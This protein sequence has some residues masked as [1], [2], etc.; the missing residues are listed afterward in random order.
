VKKYFATA[1]LAFAACKGHKDVVKDPQTT[2]PTDAPKPAWVSARP[3]ADYDYIGIGTCPKTRADYQ[4]SAKK[5]ALNDMASEISVRVEGNSLLSSLDDKTHFT[6]TFNSNIRTST[7]EQLEGYEQVD[8][9]QNATE[10]WVYY[11]LSKAEHARIK[12]AKKNQAIALAKDGYMRAQQQLVNGDLK[13]AFDQDLRA[14]IAMKEYWGESDVVTIGDREVPLAN[15]IF[16]DLQRLTNGVRFSALPE[17]CALDYTNRFKRELLVSAAFADGRQSRDLV[18]LPVVIDYPG[19]SGKVSESKST[20]TDGRVRTTVQRVEMSGAAAELVVRLNVEELVSK[21]IDPV[22]V[23]PLV[24]S[25]TIPELRVPIDRT[26]PKVHI[27][28][29]ETNLGRPV[30]AGL[31]MGIKEELTS[32]G[33]RFTDR[34]TDADLLM[35]VQASTRQGG[36]SSG[37]YTTLLDVTYTFRDRRTNETIVEGGKQGLKGIQLDYV[38]AGMDAYKKAGNE[39]RKDLVSSMMNALL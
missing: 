8:T 4:E 29:D 33:F 3:N 34:V 39:L 10:F 24:S 35:D 6:E 16:A 18:Q 30:T 25:L 7:N 21:D 2:A 38:K 37:F 20:D 17:R 32:K 13:G 26:M 15:E 14:L 27:T 23:K 31:A 11:R 22:F 12:N 28:S 19:L 1:L 9:W 5:N 36:E